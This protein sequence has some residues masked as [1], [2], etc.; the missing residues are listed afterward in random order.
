MIVV[1]IGVLI[2]AVI[3]GASAGLYAFLT[4]FALYI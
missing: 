2:L 4:V 3:L 1:R